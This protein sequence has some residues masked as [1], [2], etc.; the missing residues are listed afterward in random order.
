MVTLCSMPC[1][2]EFV[3]PSRQEIQP[4]ARVFLPV[5]LYKARIMAMHDP[6]R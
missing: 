5:A 2:W 1:Q 4:L 6:G 3:A